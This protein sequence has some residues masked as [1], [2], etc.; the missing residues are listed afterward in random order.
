[1]IFGILCAWILVIPSSSVKATSVPHSVSLRIHGIPVWIRAYAADGQAL[2]LIQ[3]NNWW[4]RY[5]VANVTYSFTFGHPGNVWLAIRF[6]QLKTH[7]TATFYASGVNEPPLV[8]SHRHNHLTIGGAQPM[9]TLSTNH[10]GWILNGK[11]NYNLIEHVW[12]KHDRAI[13][14][15]DLSVPVKVR[16]GGVGVPAWQVSRALG[17]RYQSKTVHNFGYNVFG[18]TLR[19]ANAP[20]FITSPATIPLFPY[21]SL[22]F[23][24][25]DGIANG[26]WFAIN[27]PPLFFNV[28]GFVLEQFPFVGFEYA[29]IYG[30]NSYSPPP[31]VDFESPFAFYGFQSGRLADMLIREEDFPPG[32]TGG[33]PPINIQRSLFRVSWKTNNAQL[34]EY[35]LQL[36][37]FYPDKKLMKIGPASFYGIAAN[38]LPSVLSKTWPFVTFV[39][40]G[41]G[42]PGSEGNYFYGGAGSPALWN[43]VGG[44]STTPTPYLAHPYLMPHVTLS[45]NS[46]RGLPPGFRGEYSDNYFRRPQLYSSSIDHLVH[47]LYAQGGVWNLGHRLILRTKSMDGSPY[48]NVWMLQRVTGRLKSYRWKG[49]TL[50]TLYDVSPFLI[51]NSTQ[52]VTLKRPPASAMIER[53]ITPPQGKSEWKAFSHASAPFQKG[54]A[55]TRLASWVNDF[56]GPEVQLAHSQLLKIDLKARSISLWLNVKDPVNAAPILGKAATHLSPGIYQFLYRKS[57]N[58]WT[59]LPATLPH[60]KVLSLSLGSPRAYTPGTSKTTIANLGSIPW[61]GTLAIKINRAVVWKLDKTIPGHTTVRLTIRWAPQ[62][63]GTETFVLLGQNSPVAQRQISVRPALRPSVLDIS[64][65]RALE[66]GLVTLLMLTGSVLTWRRIAWTR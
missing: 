9:V 13:P 63:A 41:T 62:G 48:Q 54:R 7:D 15:K 23:L 55:P 46:H 33:L 35:S 36:A 12:P 18:A 2:P 21:F 40:L 49:H 27:P 58:A 6:C 44:L 59:I 39:Q 47:L 65:D 50:D 45:D 31:H 57:N 1:M 11:T 38:R 28:L 30:I 29:G 34:W 10:G 43:W 22:G 3:G 26:N 60:L 66:T 61:S 37:G 17:K 24:P 16:V 4:K 19:M 20:P 14:K 32:D 56:P 64:R 8:L 25:G 5:G 42:Y 51:S 52:G 53:P